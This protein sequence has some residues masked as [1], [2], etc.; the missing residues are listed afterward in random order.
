[1]S[2]KADKRKPMAESI[3]A[4]FG[5]STFRDEFGG[6][7]YTQ[8]MPK[9]QIVLALGWV[10]QAKGPVPVWC[11]ET[12]YA[13]TLRHEQALLRAC[14]AWLE[15]YAGKP[16]TQHDAAV[17][18]FAAALGIRSL[19]GHRFTTTALAEYAFLLCCRRERLQAQMAT[20][21]AWLSEQL[22]EGLREFK[23][24]LRHEQVAA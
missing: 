9:H 10:Q 7:G 5:S 15:G 3:A 16:K 14:L 22:S 18:R 6:S 11:M 4:L 8:E 1:M 23:Q 17:E 12:F 24:Q 2:D 21:E 13:G 19:A 20:A